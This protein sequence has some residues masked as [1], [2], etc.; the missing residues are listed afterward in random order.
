MSE[1][2]KTGPENHVRVRYIW[3]PPN[4]RKTWALV[5][6]A[7]GIL[8][9]GCAGG[10]ASFLLLESITKAF[11]PI[12]RLFEIATT[13]ML[14]LGF[15]FMWGL[16][17]ERLRYR[18]SMKTA[19]ARI[20]RLRAILSMPNCRKRLPHRFIELKLLRRLPTRGS[21][22]NLI[23]QLP[24]ATIVIVGG[25]N[26]YDPVR[27][28]NC[29]VPFEPIDLF[30]DAERSWWLFVNNLRS[31][32]DITIEEVPELSAYTTR[33]L[34]PRKAELKRILLQHIL[35]IFAVS[36]VF[37]IG[38][39][40]PGIIFSIVA[41]VIIA[42]R[43]PQFVEGLLFPKTW[44]LVPAGLAVFETRPFRSNAR[45]SVFLNSQASLVIHLPMGFFAIGNADR[46]FAARCAP[47]HA[48]C[49]LAAWLSTARTPTESEI[50]S[51][52]DLPAP[53]DSNA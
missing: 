27:L 47:Y 35:I 14:C 28:G 38:W 41:S 44:W 1:Q 36:F 49:V 37:K 15:P 4:H 53:A 46:A 23:R 7:V 11:G 2:F 31:N 3:T 18:T 13:F 8:L 40:V 17:I 19:A 30:G 22:S 10:S 25:S 48:W 39:Y 33:G 24:P 45:S 20:R 5:A 52:L 6:L 32:P 12:P 51:F 21:L 43:I 9:S 16:F 34:L 29:D 50:R 42:S 26:I